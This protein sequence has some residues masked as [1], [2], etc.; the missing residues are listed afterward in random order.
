MYL[1]NF[2]DRFYNQPLSELSNDKILISCLNAHSFNILQI[3]DL[4]QSAIQ[5]SDI[6]LPDG[7]AIVYALRF[8]KGMKISK[9]SGHMLFAYEMERLN[10]I[11]GKCF[12]LGSSKSTNFL[13]KMRALREYP[14][15]TVDSFSPP[16]KKEFSEEDNEIMI[17]KINAFHP[18]V[19][20][21]GMTAPKQ[22]KW[23]AA[24]FDD[25]KVK[26]ICCIGAVFDFYAGTCKRAP[27]WMIDMGFEWLHRLISEPKRL[28]RR[29][30][31]GNT[32]FIFLIF[33]EKLKLIGLNDNMPVHNK[34]Q[35]QEVKINITK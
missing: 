5:K 13:I 12:F 35:H 2:K 3:D 16:Y 14:N 22:E 26:H 6:I 27:K 34:I 15:V 10:R 24:H 8:L 31:F 20:F 32:Q 28:W 17:R 4:Y 21:I 33:L 23:A 30:I 11:N 25:L 29:Y 1:S 19:L 18:D 9:I 7:I